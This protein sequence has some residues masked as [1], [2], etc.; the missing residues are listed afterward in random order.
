VNID[1]FVDGLNA[2]NPLAD[3]T[4]I[5]VRQISFTGFALKGALN[6]NN[7]DPNKALWL[8]YNGAAD[9]ESGAAVTIFDGRKDG[10]EGTAGADASNEKARG[11]NPDI[12]SNF[13]DVLGRG[14]TTEGVTNVTKPLFASGSP[15]MVIP[16]GEDMEVEIIYD[17]ETEDENLS[18]NLS[19]GKTK[20][21]S[22]ENRIM[23]TVSFGSEGM[24]NGKHYTLNLHLGMNSV[25]FDAA[26]SPWEE[27][28]DKP[29]ADLPLNMPSF[30]ANTTAVENEVEITSVGQPY[31][32]AVYGLTPGEAVTA[33]VVGA[34]GGVLFGKTLDV[35][36][37]GDFST[38]SVGSGNANTS[39]IAYIRVT[40]GLAANNTVNNIAKSGIISV[41]GTNSNK[42]VQV[43]MAQFASKLDLG[44]ATIDAGANGEIVL[45]SG[46]T[47]TWPSDV[48]TPD[49]SHNSS[50][51]IKKNGVR[52]TYNGTPTAANEFGWTPGSNTI[53]I[54][55]ATASALGDV[56]DITVKAGD[57]A[58]ETFVA[59][60]G[61][62]SFTPASFSVIFGE[63]GKVYPYQKTGT[64]TVTANNWSSATTSVATINPTTGVITTASVGTSVITANPTISD[65]PT[66]GWY[67]TAATKTANYTL[68]VNKQPATISIATPTPS[69]TLTTG[70]V[71]TVCTQAATLTGSITGVL[72]AS[73]SCGTVTYTVDDTTNFTVDASG[74]LETKATTP[75]ATY[76]VKVTATVADGTEYTYA[77]KTASYTIT[78]TVM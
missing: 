30:V 9:I 70:S 60:V 20:G 54:G 44:V 71:Q 13:N 26:V 14:N 64:G 15:A 11:L 73:T 48:A 78:V 3:K 22:I 55:G 45:S 59:S 24:Q 42:E 50:I 7:T 69:T 47:V 67:Y 72:A 76:I 53:T 52:L 56:Y 49:N 27:A 75:A 21:S 25:K 12:I 33:T 77:T 62:I 58:A 17:V 74:Q 19:D 16:T 43:S 65:D 10:K 29:E 63:T 66:N 2:N 39:G 18:T 61:G 41:K 35:S 57:A 23:K 51:I 1:A 36:S 6:L 31:M 40:G 32:F 68:T 5:Y 37:V 34:T 8:D 28:T 38:V 46:A 4:K